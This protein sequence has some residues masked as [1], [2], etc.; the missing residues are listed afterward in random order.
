GLVQQTLGGNVELVWNCEETELV[1]FA[2]RSQLELALVNL[3]IN[4]RDA[5]P[6]GGR[7]AVSIAVVPA[8]SDMPSFPA[9]SYLSI[10][11]RDAGPG[12][13]PAVLER[14]TEPFF[15]T[16]E[17]GKGTGLGLSMV[18]G[19]VEQSGGRIE[20]DS[21]VGEGTSVRLLMP[22]VRKPEVAE[23]LVEVSRSARPVSLRRIL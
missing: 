5:M 10:E 19:F 7:I 21:I 6:G 13:P 9:A 14:I 12:I 18:L 1:L 8:S 4:A 16:K 17:V 11:V 2:D 22:A 15:T 23:R 20:I 3:I